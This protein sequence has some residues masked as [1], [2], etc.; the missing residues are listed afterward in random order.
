M[1]GAAGM[2]EAEES[3]YPARLDVEYPEGG[4]SRVSTF[5]RIVLVV[6]VAIIVGLLGSDFAG[7]WEFDWAQW[8]LNTAGGLLTLWTLWSGGVLVLPTLL[9]LVF[10]RKYPRWWFDWHLELIRF[11]ARVGAYVSLMRDEY[12]STDE[13]QAVR[14]DL[15]YPDASGDLS[16][17]L[18]LVKWLLAIPH[19]IAL[20]ALGMASFVCVVLAWFAIV[21]TGRYPRGLFDFV[22]G[23][24]RW[25]LRVSAYMWLLITDRY[26][27]FTE[28]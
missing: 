12:P 15:D 1:S 9:M 27:P 23:V 5:F 11:T 14:L 2:S 10:R 28:R 6:P 18:P 3:R 25:A 7:T 21:F 13:E 26:P 16:R 20:L 19:Y 17:W 8:A 4:L 24:Q 22:L